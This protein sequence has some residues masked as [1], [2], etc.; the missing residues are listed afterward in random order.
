AQVVMVLLTYTLRQWQIWKW[1]EENLAH[2]TPEGLLRVLKLLQQWV[3][4][5]W[6]MSY[7][8]LPVVSFTRE[9]MQLEGEARAKA[10]RK[11]EALEAN[12]FSPVPNARPLM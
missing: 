10:L 6:Q 11:L 4:I 12:L 5:Y 2:L 9:A 8:Q 7:V 3:V 1:L